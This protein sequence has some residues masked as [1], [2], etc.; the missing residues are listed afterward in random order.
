MPQSQQFVL[1]SLRAKASSVRDRMAAKI[2]KPTADKIA[3]EAKRWPMR[4]LIKRHGLSKSQIGRIV[5]G[6]A[7]A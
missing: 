7:W 5:R 6:E 2:D 4:V 3:A 1:R